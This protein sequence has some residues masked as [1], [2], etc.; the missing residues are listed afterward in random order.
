MGFADI[1]L[2]FDSDDTLLCTI[3]FTLIK[4]CG[5]FWSILVVLILP[6]IPDS[7]VI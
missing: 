3:S 4:N 5:E 7:L 6:T 1:A 2:G